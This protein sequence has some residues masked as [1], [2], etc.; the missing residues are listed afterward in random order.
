LPDIDDPDDRLRIKRRFAQTGLVAVAAAGV[1]YPLAAAGKLWSIP[2]QAFWTTWTPLLVV[3][4]A[5][6]FWASAGRIKVL[7]DRVLAREATTREVTAQAE[8]THR[9][10]SRD[11]EREQRKYL[12]DLACRWLVVE[13]AQQTKLPLDSFGASVWRLP[14][15][16][17]TQRLRRVIHG[18]VEPRRASRIPWSKGKG[19]IGSTWEREEE[20]VIDLSPLRGL[21]QEAFEVLPV[22]ERL[23]LSWLEFCRVSCYDACWAIPLY[24][25]KEGDGPM[26]GVLSIDCKATNC[27]K[28]IID[29][30][31]RVGG[32]VDAV[33]GHFASW[34]EKDG[35]GE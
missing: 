32:L 33:Y 17:E 6:G 34:R 28:P 2:T 18:P 4:P 1:A 30:I 11:L 12:L 16:G 15:E 29:A 26:L 23:G 13:L 20:L 25:D 7:Q 21:N 31:P 10:L 8:I 24:A 27:S 9:K 22:Q 3:L 35:P 5:L 14:R 19:V